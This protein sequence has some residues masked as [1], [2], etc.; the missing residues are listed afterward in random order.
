MSETT[1]HDIMGDRV[2]ADSENS[3]GQFFDSK[4]GRV[5]VTGS[6]SIYNGVIYS[7]KKLRFN[8]KVHR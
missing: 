5:T 3:W 8:R 6:S 4:S 7:S 1:K 2:I